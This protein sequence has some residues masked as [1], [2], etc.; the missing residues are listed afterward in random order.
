MEL[1]DSTEDA[2]R[3]I[4]QLQETQ[5]QLLA[6]MRRELALLPPPTRSATRARR[7][8]VR[9]KKRR[10]LIE[11]L[12]EIEKRINEENARPKSATSARP[13]ARR[14]TRSTTTSCAAGS[15]SAARATS[16]STR[17]KALRRAGDERDGGRRG[18]RARHRGGAARRPRRRSTARGGH[19]Q[20]GGAFSAR[21]ARRCGARPTSW[22][23]PRASS[24]RATRPLDHLEE[25]AAMS[26]GSPTATRW[27]ATRSSTASRPSSTPSSRGR[28]ASADYGRLLCPLAAFAATLR[29]F[30]AD[31]SAGAVARLQ[32]HR[33]VHVRGLRALAARHRARCAPRPPTRCASTGGRRRLAGRQHRRHRPVRDIEANAGVALENACC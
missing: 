29:A 3:Q 12:A 16:P 2:R 24:S 32:R 28:P 4:E 26:A 21:S 5:Q 30:A 11:L 22:S 9:W 7:R 31:R 10:R 25:H 13:R 17:A 1:G 20:G 18:P 19:R 8:S 23:S 33:A 27:P 15:R 6:Q 14:S